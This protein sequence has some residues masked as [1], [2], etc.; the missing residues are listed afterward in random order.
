MTKA[1]KTNKPSSTGEAKTTETDSASTTT[2][3]AQDGVMQAAITDIIRNVE[4]VMKAIIDTVSNAL[5][6]KLV[7]NNSFID[8]LSQ[9]LMVQKV[10][11]Y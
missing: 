11:V 9:K 4:S 6:T 3:P 2:V 5:V 10:V 1:K 8:V 7:A